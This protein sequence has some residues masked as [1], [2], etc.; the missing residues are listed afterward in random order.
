MPTSLSHK[1]LP[2]SSSSSTAKNNA[3]NQTSNMMITMDYN[4]SNN[5]MTKMAKIKSMNHHHHSN[6]KLSFEQPQLNGDDNNND[7]ETNKIEVNDLK[8]HI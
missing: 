4:D 1:T 7:N 2:S 6:R 8:I 5:Q 3:K